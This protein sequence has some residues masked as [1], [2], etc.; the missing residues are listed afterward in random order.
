VGVEAISNLHLRPNLGVGALILNLIYYFETASSLWADE[1]HPT[2]PLRV[3]VKVQAPRFNKAFSG[4]R[5]NLELG[6]RKKTKAE[7]CD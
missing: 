2:K 3:R 5:V 4:S 6:A 1:R 7:V